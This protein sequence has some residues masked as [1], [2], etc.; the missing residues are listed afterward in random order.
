V[1]PGQKNPRYCGTSLTPGGI[2]KVYLKRSNWVDIPLGRVFNPI[3][4]NAGIAIHGYP[5]VPKNPA[6][7][8]CVRVPMHIAQYLPDLLH[9]GDQVFVFDGQKQPEIYGDQKPPADER[10]PTDTTVATTTTTTIKPTTTVAGTTTTKP[11]VPAATTVP[12]ATTV[13]PVPVPTTSV[14]VTVSPTT[15]PPPPAPTT[16]SPTSVKAAPVTS[17]AA[18]QAA[19]TP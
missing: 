13:K 9:T 17:A 12:T 10:D 8:G 16:V 5:D 4:F 14:P 3:S 19:A 18:A 15:G 7:H 2:F 11:T 1:P 6:S